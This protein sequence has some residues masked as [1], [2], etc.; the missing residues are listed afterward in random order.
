M[1]T[2]VVVKRSNDWQAYLIE[3]TAIWGCGKSPDEAIGNL[4]CSHQDTF[5]ISVEVKQ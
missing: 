2:V 3:N 1:K 4:I 5:H